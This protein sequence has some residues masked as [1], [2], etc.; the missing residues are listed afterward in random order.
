[1]F[2]TLNPTTNEVLAF[3]ADGREEDVAAAVAAARRAFDE[4]PWPRMSATE[5]AAVL[6]L[7][8]QGIRDNAE[9]LIAREVADIGMPLSR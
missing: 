9:E 7:I 3:A 6:R 2:E 5:R 4:G 1:M 8:A